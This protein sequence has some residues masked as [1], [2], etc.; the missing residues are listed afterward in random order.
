MDRVSYFCP[1]PAWMLNLL[2]MLPVQLGPQVHIWLVGW[3][4]I[5]LTFYPGWPWTAVLPI[6]APWVAGIIILCHNT[7]GQETS[8]IFKDKNEL[9]LKGCRKF[10]QTVIY[11]CGTGVQIQ[12]LIFAR[13]VLVPVGPLLQPSNSYQ[14]RWGKYT[15]VRQN[16]L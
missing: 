2:P 6:S 4:G 3:D 1:W 9:K 11:F 16:R 10:I 8:F 13:Q 5:L 12:G 14:Q 7:W 15:N